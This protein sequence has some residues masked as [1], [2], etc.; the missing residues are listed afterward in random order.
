MFNHLTPVLGCAL[1]LTMPSGVT[2]QGIEFEWDAPLKCPDGETVRATIEQLL[3]NGHPQAAQEA[4]AHCIHRVNVRSQHAVQRIQNHCQHCI[5][6]LQELGAPQLAQAVGQAC[7]N[8]VEAIASSRMAAV[9]AIQEAL[10]GEPASADACGGDLDDDGVVGATDLAGLIAAWGTVPAAA[11]DLDGDGV[12]NSG[13]VVELLMVWGG[14][15][16]K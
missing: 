1:L 5:Q 7:G 12:V 2:A 4:A 10:G 14:C 6:V 8:A 3:K 15:P 13:D 11:R 9:S 16:G